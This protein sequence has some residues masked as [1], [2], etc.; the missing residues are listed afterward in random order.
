LRPFDRLRVTGAIVEILRYAQDDNFVPFVVQWFRGP[1]G[2]VA[3][4]KMRHPLKVVGLRWLA[5]WLYNQSISTYLIV[6]LIW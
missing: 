4:N 5:F 6:D 1:P 2:F 3:C